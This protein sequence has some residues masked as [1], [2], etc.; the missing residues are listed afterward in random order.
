M[1]DKF[2]R[3][4]NILTA[5]SEQTI[6]IIPQE[7]SLGNTISNVLG[8]IPQSNNLN[9]FYNLFGQTGTLVPFGVGDGAFT[10][11][12][13]YLFDVLFSFAPVESNVYKELRKIITSLSAE[14]LKYLIQSIDLPDFELIDEPERVQTQFGYSVLPGRYVLPSTNELTI[15]FISAEKSVLESVFYYWMREISNNEWSYNS[16]PYTNSNI[17]LSFLDQQNMTRLNRYIIMNAIPVSVGSISPDQSSEQIQFTRSV[18]FKFSNIIVGKPSIVTDITK[19]VSKVI[20]GQEVESTFGDLA[21]L[22]ISLL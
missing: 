6:G 9:T 21:D 18:K 10:I 1:A 4:T 5:V 20:Q 12:R 19:I 14:S 13:F 22:G 7:S 17:Y 15:N 11:Q 3:L 16:R 8:G 2:T